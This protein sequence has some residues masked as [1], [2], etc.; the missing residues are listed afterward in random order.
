MVATLR[1]ELIR[2]RPPHYRNI[3]F[4]KFEHPAVAAMETL[5][6]KWLALYALEA[7]FHR[8]SGQFLQVYF[9]QELAADRRLLAEEDL[10]DFLVGTPRTAEVPTFYVAA[11][12]VLLHDFFDGKDFRA[13]GQQLRRADTFHRTEGRLK[14]N[15]QPESFRLVVHPSFDT[16]EE[17]LVHPKRERPPKSPARALELALGPGEISFQARVISYSVFHSR[18]GLIGG[19]D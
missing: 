18:N 16:V 17:L 2:T 4:E 11:R 5:L 19:R 15:G 1:D 6:V 9:A 7:R 10:P 12:A 14:L 8:R 13:G 3:S